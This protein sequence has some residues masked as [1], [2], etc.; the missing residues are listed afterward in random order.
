MHFC[1]SCGSVQGFLNILRVKLRNEI[2][3]QGDFALDVKSIRSKKAGMKTYYLA[4]LIDG[5]W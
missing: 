3:I 1:P 4:L 2:W 5:I